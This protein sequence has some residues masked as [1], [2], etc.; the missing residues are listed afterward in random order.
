MRPAAVVPAVLVPAIAILAVAALL[1]SS[2][3]AGS[4]DGK[5]SSGGHGRG[6]GFLPGYDPPEVAQWRKNFERRP[7]YWYGGPQFYRGR[8]NG[9]GFGPCWTPTPI[10]PHWNCG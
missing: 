7:A 8:W 10:G 9:G 1:L 5:R 2:A 4:M 3:S 6:H